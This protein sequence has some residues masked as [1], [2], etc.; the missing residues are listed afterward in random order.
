MCDQQL[1]VHSNQLSCV[2]RPCDVLWRLISFLVL[3]RCELTVK[4]TADN[5][6]SSIDLSLPAGE[7]HHRHYA[8]MKGSLS[9]VAAEAHDLIQSI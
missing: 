9:S 3:W 2:H 6:E 8:E 7:S 1:T 5:T 4:H